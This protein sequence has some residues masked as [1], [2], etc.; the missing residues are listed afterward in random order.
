MNIIEDLT[1]NTKER[2]EIFLKRIKFNDDTEL[3]LDRNSIIVFTGA[4]N[5]GKSQVLKDIE[6]CLEQT[7]YA[8]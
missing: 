8:S 7:K 2:P 1:A 4:N 5:S 3:L 6:R